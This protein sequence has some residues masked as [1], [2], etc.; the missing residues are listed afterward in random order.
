MQE[1]TYSMKICPKCKETKK[2][3]DF[4][5]KNTYCKV[6]SKKRVKEWYWNNGGKEKASIYH[7]KR[8]KEK[9]EEYR[10]AYKK[11]SW[12]YKIDCINIYGGKCACC[13][14]K[15][16]KFL[17]IDHIAG[18]GN[19]HRKEIKKNKIYLWLKRMGYPQGFQVLC[20]NCNMAK[21][22]WVLCPHKE[23]K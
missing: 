8:R 9:P 12:K 22:Y 11:W 13:G 18:N 6:C 15:E 3:D 5:P 16:P 4:Y 1:Y 10:I 20:H 7:K 14:E 19:S 2:K 17:A 21:A 23:K